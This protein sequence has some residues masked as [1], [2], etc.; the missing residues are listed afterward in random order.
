MIG[1]LHHTII[2]CPD[3][4][5]LAEFYSALLGKPVTYRSDDFCVV[6]DNATTSGI[7]FQRVPEFH[8]PRWPDP[9]YPQQIHF[10]VMVDD[11]ASARK[12]V[13]AIGAT[14][15]ADGDNVYADPVGHPFCLVR[16]PSWAPRMPE[17]SE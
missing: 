2:D 3:P 11:L 8:A 10:D 16:R 14:P 13:I 1:R 7:G 15:I 6:A 17:A 5:R 9:A 4:S 12:A